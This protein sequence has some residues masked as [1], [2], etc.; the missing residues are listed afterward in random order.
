[1]KYGI[2]AVFTCEG[3]E[4]KYTNYSE[5]IFNSEEEALKAINDNYGEQLAQDATIDGENEEDL[6]GYL[7]EDL[8]P[9]AI[10]KVEEIKALFTNDERSR[11]FVEAGKFQVIGV[12]F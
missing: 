8:E 4:D 1:M 5:Q 7:Y 2:R 6:I 12:G 3:K 10:E 9:Y 11:P